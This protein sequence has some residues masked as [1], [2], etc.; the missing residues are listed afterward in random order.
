MSG[1]K[2]HQTVGCD[3]GWVDL[4]CLSTLR[5]DCAVKVSN[6]LLFGGTFVNTACNWGLV[7][8]LIL[9]NGLCQHP[10][11]S[12][13]ASVQT[14]SRIS[15]LPSKSKTISDSNQ[16]R[17]HHNQYQ[18]QFNFKHKYQIKSHHNQG[19]VEPQSMQNH[20][21]HHS[22]F[23][24][25]KWMLSCQGQLLRP[26]LN[27]FDFDLDQWIFKIFAPHFFAPR[28]TSCFCFTQ[29]GPNEKAAVKVGRSRWYLFSLSFYCSGRKVVLSINQ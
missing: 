10:G 28:I 29:V 17:S 25:E 20:L 3:C 4:I 24:L 23:H 26:R 6:F 13:G 12:S 2:L 16:I 9:A 18:S 1:H 8:C 5:F 7:S 22:Q 14:S 11:S 15:N 27:E 21:K 19:N